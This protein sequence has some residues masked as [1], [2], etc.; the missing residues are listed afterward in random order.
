MPVNKPHLYQSGIYFITFT[1]YK[2]LHLIQQTNAYDL[3]YKWF[4]SLKSKGHHIVGYVIMPNHI[5]VLVAYSESRQS[6]NTAIGNGKRFMAYG[7]IERLK[8]AGAASMLHTLAA[9]VNTSDRRKGKRHEVF[10]SSFDVKDCYNLKVVKQKLDYVHA[11]PLSGKWSLAA[12]YISYPHSSARFYETGEQG[13]YPV[14][15][16]MDIIMDCFS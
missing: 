11:N 7:I 9:G 15:S 14:T 6:L 3:V 13:I 1:N 10:E 12:D 2:W 8:L 4:D 16:Y 5:H